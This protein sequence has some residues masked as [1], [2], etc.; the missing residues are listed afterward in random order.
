MFEFIDME[1]IAFTL[2]HCNVLSKEWEAVDKDSNMK[3]H[4]P[5]LRKKK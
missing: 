4:R 5:A 2:I 3:Q 1:R